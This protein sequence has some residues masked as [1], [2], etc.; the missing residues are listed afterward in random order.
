MDIILKKYIGTGGFLMNKVM[1]IG[2]ITKDIELKE[3]KENNKYL[4]SFKLAV[5]R[6]FVNE[7]GERGADFIPVVAWEKNAQNLA[8]YTKKGSLISIIG[9][10]QTRDYQTKDGT[11]KYISE[12][13]AQEI[14]FLDSR[15]QK[16]TAV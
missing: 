4:A 15:K 8:K 12:V 11:K 14:Q 13:I 5:N 10:L 1:F 7:N 2:R 9:R 6:D 16:E 3:I